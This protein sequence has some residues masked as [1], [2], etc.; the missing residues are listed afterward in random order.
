MKKNKC[1][2]TKILKAMDEVLK[3]VN[4]KV[5]GFTIKGIKYPP[6]CI[7][8]SLIGNCIPTRDA[9]FVCTRLEERAKQ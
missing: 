9:K 4:V 6:E 5:A 3:T 8:C 1:I 7:G 2:D